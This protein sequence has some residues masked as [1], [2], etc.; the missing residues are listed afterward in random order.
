MLKRKK[1]G[2]T[3]F[4]N[5]YLPSLL[6]PIGGF[7]GQC[8]IGIY[9]MTF[10]QVLVD[11]TAIDQLAEGMLGFSDDAQELLSQTEMTTLFIPGITHTKSLTLNH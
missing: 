3:T 1:K 4:L 7:I 10:S 2:T 5:T 11:T 8:S 6:P 9:P